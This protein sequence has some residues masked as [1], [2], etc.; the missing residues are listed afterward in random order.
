VLVNVYGDPRFY[1]V[2]PYLYQGTINDA[3]WCVVAGTMDVQQYSDFALGTARV[4]RVVAAVTNNT[5]AKGFVVLAKVDG[6]NSPTVCYAFDAVEIYPKL[7]RIQPRKT[8]NGDLFWRLSQALVE[9]GFVV[10]ER[11][12]A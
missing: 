1:Q 6:N 8:R 11:S 2:E 9:G 3:R 5:I 7:Q 12:W 10:A 4:E